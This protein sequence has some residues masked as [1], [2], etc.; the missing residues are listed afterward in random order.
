MT[1]KKRQHKRENLAEYL[2]GLID[3]KYSLQQVA[4]F[5]GYTV[6][7]LCNLKKRFSKEGEK[8][9][10]NGHT[11]KEPATKIDSETRN[12]I[13]DIYQ[14]EFIEKD[15]NGNVIRTYNFNFFKNC[16]EEFHDIKYSYKSIY[17][18]LDEVGIVS[19][20]KHKIKKEK[21]LHRPRFRREQAGDMIQMDATP[22][23]WFKWC[24]DTSYYALHGAID[25][26][27]QKATGFSISENECSYGYYDV[28]EQTALNFGLPHEI[29]TDR[30]AI[31][32]ATPKNKDKLTIQEQ[33]AGLKEKRTQWQRILSELSVKQ[34]LSW[35]PQARG[36]I[37][38]LWRT[39]QGRLPWYFKKHKIKTVEAA[40]EFL[41]NHYIH[42]FNAEFSFEREKD[43]VWRTPPVNLKDLICSRFSRRVNSA[44]VIS[45][46]GYKFIVKA[47]R[48]ARREIEL[49]IFKDGLKALVDNTYY[50]VEIT[51]DLGTC[52]GDTMSESL[53]EIL[54]REMY[55]DVKQACA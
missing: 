28:L 37:E 44:G 39:L 35:T 52:A 21:P 33:L 6:V 11:G 47:P 2:Q 10:I 26:A 15:K 38:R 23:Q 31:F 25:D 46:Q 8:C 54:Y 40:N 55:S 17:N 9:L 32:C 24:G 43:D 12:K 16:L 34:I 53:K 13:I 4:D 45:F 3:K 27:K 48:C 41:K 51:D 50:P 1:K 18:I 14:T 19:P 20:E 22:Y 49:C 29:Y 30:A 36:R 42:I 7:H 5:T